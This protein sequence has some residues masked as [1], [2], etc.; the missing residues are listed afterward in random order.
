M[1]RKAIL[2]GAEELSENPR[3]RSAQCRVFEKI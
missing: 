3:S 1:Q 2:P